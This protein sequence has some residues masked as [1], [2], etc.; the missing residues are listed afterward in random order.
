VRHNLEDCEFVDWGSTLA[1]AEITALNIRALNRELREAAWGENRIAYW[2]HD[3]E[4]W[5]CQKEMDTSRSNYLGYARY[6]SHGA[7]WGPA[8]WS[9]N[10][11]TSFTD[12]IYKLYS[13]DKVESTSIFDSS[14]IPLLIT[15]KE[16]GDSR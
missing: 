4:S 5:H 16:I 10:V 13:S 15:F 9:K 3:E 11:G 12:L 2:T 8:S 6:Q 7:P 14:Q 1:E